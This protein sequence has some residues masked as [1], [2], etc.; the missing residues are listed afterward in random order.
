[1]ILLASIY[2]SWSI[3]CFTKDLELLQVFEKQLQRK[4]VVLEHKTPVGTGEV[5][6]Y[7]TLAVFD[8]KKNIK[9][10]NILC[11]IMEKLGRMKSSSKMWAY[12]IHWDYI[13]RHFGC[14]SMNNFNAFYQRCCQ[15]MAGGFQTLGFNRKTFLSSNWRYLLSIT[16]FI[17]SLGGT[18]QAKSDLQTPSWM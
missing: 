14:K 10:H 8:K 9:S 15:L 4:L 2:S 18:F 7:V 17:F 11:L 1:M 6:R 13:Q 5:N 16:L 12:F 3:R